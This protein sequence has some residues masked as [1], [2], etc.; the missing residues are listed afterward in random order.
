MNAILGEVQFA[1]LPDG[2]IV[3]SQIR[4]PNGQPRHYREIAPL[5]YRVEDGEARLGFVKQSDGL[6]YIFTSGAA[7]G[8]QQVTF[9]ESVGFVTFLCEISRADGSG[10]DGRFVADW[11]VDTLALWAKVE[12]GRRRSTLAD[13][14]S[15]CVRVR[16]GVG[17]WMVAVFQR[18]WTDAHGREPGC[19]S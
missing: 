13:V 9:T 7:S 12:C 2:A 17:V 18:V 4:G 5:V 11:R 10:V 15:I 6:Y 19:L 1:A 16:F 14:D 3:S 8:F